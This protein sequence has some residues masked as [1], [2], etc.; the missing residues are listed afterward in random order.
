MYSTM[1]YDYYGNPV[2]HLSQWDKN[3]SLHITDLEIPNSIMCHICNEQ[4]DSVILVAPE[5]I[6]NGFSVD[7]PNILLLQPKA[8]IL[9]IYLYGED[10][11]QRTVHIIRLPVA[12]RPRPQDYEYE[13]NIDPIDVDS[14]EPD[15][16]ELYSITST[17]TSQ[18]STLSGRVDSLTASIRTMF[19]AQVVELNSC[20]IPAGSS[21]ASPCS[22]DITI[23]SG[24]N[25][26]VLAIP[27]QSLN[28][29][30]ILWSWTFSAGAVTY[31]YRNTSDSD[32]TVTPNAYC[33]FVK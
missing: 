8:I 23:P 4:S 11:S 33:L 30:L 25:R 1:C 6:P 13:D 27:S 32:I 31:R 3:I 19:T 12:K 17:L 28:Q 7:I 10:D 9:Y 15:I 18:L 29:N 21:N 16:E 24:Y 26:C 5:N 22:T 20:V 14:F 2:N